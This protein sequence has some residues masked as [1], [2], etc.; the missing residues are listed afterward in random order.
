MNI[1]KLFQKGAHGKGYYIALVLCAMAI[2]ITGYMYARNIR[3]EKA[4]LANAGT[5]SPEIQ[6]EVA[7]IGTLPQGSTAPSASS[8]TTRPAEKEPMETAAPVQGQTVAVYAMDSLDY[9]ETTR[10][11]RVHNG[12]DIAAEAG[13]P[14]TA[15]ADGVVYTIYEDDSMGMTVV[16]R[17]EDGYVTRYSSL[18]QTVEVVSGQSVKLGQTIG[19][20]GETALLETAE[21]S[22]VHFGVTCN[23]EPMDPA[24]FCAIGQ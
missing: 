20:V 6:Q 10:D 8:E 2:G 14:V 22:H 17:H 16:I 15:A 1:R 4:Q 18:D 24:E 21:G 7:A 19:Y 12:V 9:N 3:Q 11:W 23:D 5:T 13:T